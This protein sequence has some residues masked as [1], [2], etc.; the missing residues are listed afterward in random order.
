VVDQTRLER[1]TLY[2]LAASDGPVGA[3]RLVDELS[4]HNIVLSEATVGR[5][6]RSLD[7]RGL[8]RPVGKLGRLLTEDGRGRLRHLEFMQRQGERSAVLLGATTPT[9]V[10]ELLD[11]LYTRRAVEPEAARHAALR[12][13]DLER[14]AIRAAADS[15]I[16]HVVDG[17]DHS[18]AAL[19]FHRL[20]AEASHNMMLKAVAGLTLDS[21]NSS[22]AALL[23]DI[24]TEVGA[25]FTFAHEHRTIVEAI[26]AR[27]PEAAE[28]AMREHLDDLIRVVQEYSDR[29]P[30]LDASMRSALTVNTTWQ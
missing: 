6:L 23:D 24:S 8:T 9:D 2:T 5:F 4:R 27:D 7:R 15:H 13:T 22:L 1:I 3:S 21:S 18:T 30:R 25:Q 19:D 10:D 11:L 14:A 17:T 26:L 12:A 20:V 28:A 29:H 16:H